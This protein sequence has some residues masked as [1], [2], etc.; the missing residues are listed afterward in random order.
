MTNQEIKEIFVKFLDMHTTAVQE[1]YMGQAF[2]GKSVIESAILKEV[3]N[4]ITGRREDK[5][6]TI[7]TTEDGECVAVTWQDEDHR[8]LKIVWDKK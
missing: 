7:T 3:D 2:P 5:F 8:I 6:L 4:L 1:S